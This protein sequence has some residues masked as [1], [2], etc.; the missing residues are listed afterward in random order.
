MA[1]TYKKALKTAVFTLHNGSTVTAAD[2]VDASIGSAALA[3][4]EAK[5]LIYVPGEN[6]TTIFDFAQVVSVAV[7]VQAS[8]D[9]TKDDPYCAEESAS[10]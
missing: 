1:I 3:M 8:E 9:I 6:S 2:T 5:K 4:Y 10:E 7:S